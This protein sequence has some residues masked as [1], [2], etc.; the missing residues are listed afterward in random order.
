MH[1]Q[2]LLL[3]NG[4]SQIRHSLTETDTADTGGGRLALLDAGHHRRSRSGG[5]LVL[6]ATMLGHRPMADC[7]RHALTASL[8]CYPQVREFDEADP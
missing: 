7:L 8:T 5:L 3:T 4:E 1:V 2:T 6:P